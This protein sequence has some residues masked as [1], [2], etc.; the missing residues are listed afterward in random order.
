MQDWL[1][2]SDPLQPVDLIFV[3][4][5]HRDRKA[6]GVELLG[7]QWARRILLSTF[8]AESLDL[9]RFAEL[10]LPAWPRLLE[11]QPR[12]PPEGRLFFLDYDGSAW[13]V[14]HL[15]RRLL[16]TMT[17]IAYLARWLRHHPEV[18]SVLIVS[19]GPHLRRI[20]LCCRALL[21]GQVSV[22]LA[23]VPARPQPQA[24]LAA[25]ARR[26]DGG[27]LLGEYAKLLL[28]RVLLALG[29]ARAWSSREP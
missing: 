9:S 4:A 25:N 18:R 2:R 29:A 15:H 20:R 19:S 1:V 11:W 7:Q 12:I 26:Q 16:G 27:P 21:P 14:E 8:S 24:P 13:R 17:E 28:Y 5:G 22:R 10:R 3:L 23:A 6:Y